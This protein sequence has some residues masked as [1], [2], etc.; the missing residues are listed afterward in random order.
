[1]V[2]TLGPTLGR[3]RR[4]RRQLPDS[5]VAIQPPA[6][7]PANPPAGAGSGLFWI[8]L[9]LCGAVGLWGML[10]PTTVADAAT[11]AVSAT[12]GA[13]SWLFM[14]VVTLFLV[15]CLY[16]ACSRLGALRLG[17]PD[18]EPEFALGSW[19]AMLFSAG[20]GSGLLFWGMAEP[21]THFLAPPTGEA[22]TRSAARQALLITN[23]H[24]GLHAWAVYAVGALVLAWFGFVRGTPYLAGAPLRSSFRGRWVEPTARFADLVAVLSVAF[25]VAGSLAMGTLQMQ[26]G[27][28]AATGADLGGVPVAMGVLGLVVVSYLASATTSLDKGI[29]W[30]SNINIALAIALLCWLLFSGPTAS[31][32]ATFMTSLGDYIAGLAG[33]SLSLRPFDDEGGWL[34]AWTLTYFVWWISWTPFVGIFI[35]RISRGRTIREFILGVLFA[36][37]LASILWFAVFGG[38]GFFH[39]LFGDPGLAALVR[40]DVT[41][42]LF[43]LLDRAPLGAA[44]I[45]V[46]LA[47][48]FIFLVTSADSAT[49][50]LGMLTSQGSLNPPTGR[51][52]AWGLALGVLSGA[53]MLTGE[54]N[55]IKALAISGAVPFTA[56]LLIQVAALVRDLRRVDPSADGDPRTP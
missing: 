20:M 29:K 27:L 5:E 22:M 46:A 39:E 48:I 3:T 30:L 50:V 8:A 36:P 34:E 25:G 53:V 6:G 15:L 7:Q 16:L 37:T 23:F 28:G 40:E 56:I 19:L 45:L 1:M 21:M 9:L 2:G 32:L 52:L 41:L 54:T 43:G 14:S 18:E 38:S 35:A 42:A 13:L 4:L 12:L 17:G 26:S 51:K 49:F 47:L 55:T 31:L 33:V 10:D 24:W 11:G 44:L